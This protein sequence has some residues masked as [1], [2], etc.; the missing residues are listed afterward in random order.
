MKPDAPTEP[1]PGIDAKTLNLIRAANLANV[2]KKVKAGKPLSKSELALLEAA[3]TTKPV[4]NPNGRFEPGDRAAAGHS[5]GG[6]NGKPKWHP[7]FIG[8]AREISKHG[9]TDE[10]IAAAFSVTER[11][12]TRWKKEHPPFASALK[13]GKDTPNKK[14]ERSL[15]E[16]ALGYSHPDTD[17]RV[18]NGTIVKTPIVK[19][20]P[21]DTT[22][23]IYWTKNRDPK[24]WRDKTEVVPQNPDGTAMNTV[25]PFVHL[26]LPA[27]RAAGIMPT[28]PP[29]EPKP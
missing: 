19:H 17:I 28:E 12:I 24:R 3:P 22:A 23:A 26:I 4:G 2:V 7:S 1:Q 11:T 13:R 14:V 10:E 27:G 18:V 16:R 5:H 20:Y 9:L 29:T 15:F 6:V 8:I 21:P 25:P